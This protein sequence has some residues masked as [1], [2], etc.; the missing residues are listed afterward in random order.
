MIAAAIGTTAM[1]RQ[2]LPQ[3][4]PGTRF[5]C[6]GANA[7]DAT[8][9]ARIAT[10]LAGLTEEVHAALRP[11]HAPAAIG[12]PATTAEAG[13]Q[14]GEQT[15]EADCVG[16]S[17]HRW[18]YA[19]GACR[20]SQA[21]CLPMGS[22]SIGTRTS[23]PRP[24]QLRSEIL[25]VLHSR[26]EDDTLHT[27]QVRSKRLQAPAG[28]IAPLAGTHRVQRLF[29]GRNDCFRCHEAILRREDEPRP[30]SGLDESARLLK[31]RRRVQFFCRSRVRQLPGHA[32]HQAQS[33]SR[34]R[35]RSVGKRSQAAG[36]GA[37]PRRRTP[38]VGRDAGRLPCR[39]R[40]LAPA[41]RILHAW[42]DRIDKSG[43]CAR[44]RPRVLQQ[45]H[46]RHVV[47]LPRPQGLADVRHS[48]AH[49][50][51]PAHFTGNDG[52]G[53]LVRPPGHLHEALPGVCS[54]QIRL[55]HRHLA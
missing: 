34:Q 48:I 40:N 26:K 20:S 37:N 43:G 30:A 19:H 3:R 33:S 32:R 14:V 8:A 55:A 45:F 21:N 2:T 51:V 36:G 52:H 54:D 47:E 11:V 39:R 46:P 5:E 17:I 28:P 27:R 41:Q 7:H 10:R 53:L 4:G 13:R 6:V 16:N 38:V 29:V 50:Q 1:L 35:R 9:S 49:P 22:P 25:P 42:L 23:T 15:I 12:K 44:L 24:R 31:P 18:S